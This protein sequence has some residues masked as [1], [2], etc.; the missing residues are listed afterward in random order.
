[1]LCD[2]FAELLNEQIV[3]TWAV[4][5]APIEDLLKNKK[6][7]KVPRPRLWMT[8]GIAL[9][10]PRYS[11]GSVF[12]ELAVYDWSLAKTGLVTLWDIDSSES[13]EVLINNSS[14]DYETKISLDVLNRFD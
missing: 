7:D 5:I 11:S 12:V 13:Y 10:L 6:G 9:F 2:A 1:M 8:R 14:N 3:P 4:A